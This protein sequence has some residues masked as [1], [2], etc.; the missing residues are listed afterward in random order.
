MKKRLFSYLVTSGFL[1]FFLSIPG[2]SFSQNVGIGISNPA[3]KLHVGEG[4]VR[5]E[6]SPLSYGTSVSIGGG[7]EIKIDANGIVGGRLI[8]LENGNVG[9]GHISPSQKLAVNGS[10]YF[11]G[12]LGIGINNPAS[13]LDIIHDGA[14]AYGTVILLNQS[15]FGNSD[16]PK[17]GFQKAMNIPKSWTAGIL[18]GVDIGSFSINEDAGTTGFGTSRFSIAPGGNIGIGITD[19]VYRLDVGGR[20]RI[21][22]GGGSAGLYLNS[23][24]NS[25]SPAFIGMQDDTHV[26]FW[27]NAAQW[28]F[29][30]NTTTGAL[31]INGTEGLAGQVL[32]SNGSSSPQWKSGTNSLYNNTIQIIASNIVAMTQEL[33]WTAIPGLAYSFNVS[34][35]AKVFCS[36]NVEVAPGGCFNCGP[37]TSFLGIFLDGNFVR[38]WM[39]DVPNGSFANMAAS[40]LVNVG[41]GNHTIELRGQKQ[42]PAASFASGVAFSR[43]NN[44]ILQIIAE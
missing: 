11:A 31:R 15:T 6:G 5:I 3:Y 14:S 27:G 33:T 29:T 4:T 41:A 43:S 19:P 10:G 21:R 13:N 16:G 28:N 35:N 2:W 25:Q 39:Q 24:D 38:Q 26:G 23:N 42:G 18:N 1:L 22:S 9:I 8:V 37:T 20:M 34:G 17:I 32:S 40:I 36:F 12:K 7:G 30:M 44:M